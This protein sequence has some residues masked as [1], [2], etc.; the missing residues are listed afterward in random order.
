MKKKEQIILKGKPSI[1]NC[2]S[3]FTLP[4][5]RRFRILRMENYELTQTWCIVPETE[6]PIKYE[7]QCFNPIA[8]ELVIKRAPGVAFR[9]EGLAFYGGIIIIKG[10]DEKFFIGLTDFHTLSESWL[11]PIDEDDLI[12][13]LDQVINGNTSR[14]ERLA[15][16]EKKSPIMAATIKERVHNLQEDRMTD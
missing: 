8:R 13:T 9:V 5:L 7:T 2:M 3:N 6:K 15:H 10:A 16:L 12:N 14:D 1:K 4:L 11:T